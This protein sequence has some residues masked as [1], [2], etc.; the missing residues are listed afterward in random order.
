MTKTDVKNIYKTA[1]TADH[2]QD[3]TRLCQVCNSQELAAVFV[4]CGHLVTCET[5]GKNR[6]RCLICRQKIEEIVIATLP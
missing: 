4:P 5:C 3:P 1:E 6:T 2:D